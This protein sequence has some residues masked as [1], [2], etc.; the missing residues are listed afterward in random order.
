[1]VFFSVTETTLSP[2]ADFGEAEEPEDEE[3]T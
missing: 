1:M 2:L 3:G